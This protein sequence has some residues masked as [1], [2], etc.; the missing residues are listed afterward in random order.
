MTNQNNN[1]NGKKIIEDTEAEK[2]QTVNVENLM[3]EV[4]AVYR[5]SAH[6]LP[7]GDPI[8]AS[9]GYISRTKPDIRIWGILFP[10]FPSNT[11]EKPTWKP[12]TTLPYRLED[13]EQVATYHVNHIEGYAKGLVARAKLDTAQERVRKSLKNRRESNEVQD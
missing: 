2:K 8:R 13:I 1:T 11:R 5:R 10:I 12:V 6:L 4:H 7:H 9:S 3:E